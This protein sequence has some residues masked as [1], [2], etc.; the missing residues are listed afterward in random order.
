MRAVARNVIGV[1]TAGCL[2][3][4][5]AA[6]AG[7]EPVPWRPASLVT[8]NLIMQGGRPFI[9]L[10]DLA[11]ALG[12]TGRYD[13]V[14]LRYEIQPGPSG[15]LL[16]NPGALSA[17]GF[18]GDAGQLASASSAALSSFKLLIGGQDVNVPRED[19]MMLRPAVPGISLDFLAHLLG[20]R[21]RFD[22]GKGI[23]MLP[24]GDAGT[25]LR[26]R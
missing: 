17:I 14:R 21:A 16:V 25:P 11:R 7:I 19:R 2:V 23:W 12:G 13:A 10:G 6:T 8:N 4:V 18:G 15:V 22:A 24:A 9:A 3:A 20:G 26:F 1:G 5:A